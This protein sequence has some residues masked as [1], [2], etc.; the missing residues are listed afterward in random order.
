[1][2][3]RQGRCR[4]ST[5]NKSG[6]RTPPL[7]ATQAEADALAAAAGSLAGLVGLDPDDIAS[8][9]LPEA[10]HS[11]PAALARDLEGAAQQAR[12]AL[13]QAEAQLAAGSWQ[14][15]ACASL[16]AACAS[17]RDRCGEAQAALAAAQAGRG[18]EQPPSPGLAV[19]DL[20]QRLKAAAAEVAELEAR[21]S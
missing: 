1:M 7:A 11:R 6:A 16:L 12:Q 17:L 10:G 13:R 18:G 2:P 9:L 19:A 4:L 21:L 14:S 15:G 3:T 5:A 20:E 8:V